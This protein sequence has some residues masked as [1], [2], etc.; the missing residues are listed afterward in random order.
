MLNLHLNLSITM[1]STLKLS[2]A[3]III[4][5]VSFISSCKEDEQE[6]DVMSSFTFTVDATDFKKDTITNQSYILY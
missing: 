4:L 1:K 2:W 5:L 3:L 6:P